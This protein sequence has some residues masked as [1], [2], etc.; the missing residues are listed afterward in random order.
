MAVAVIWITAP[1][2]FRLN[3]L[4]ANIN[5]YEY[6]G[7]CKQVLFLIVGC[8]SKTLSVYVVLFAAFVLLVTLGAKSI[9]QA[10]DIYDDIEKYRINVNEIM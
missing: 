3:K 8:T 2:L 6:L 4:V 1:F 10:I 9:T 5:A 7:L